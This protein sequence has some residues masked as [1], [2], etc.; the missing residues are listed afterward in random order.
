MGD[1]PRNLA[2]PSHVNAWSRWS[3]GTL[4]ARLS[5]LSLPGGGVGWT[6]NVAIYVPF[7]LSWPYNV[8]RAFWGNGNAV[9]GN[10]DIGIYTQG[11]ARLWSSGSTAC[12]GPTNSLQYVTTS[13]DLTLQPGVP[14]FFGFTHDSSTASHLTGES[15]SAM[16]TPWG[17]ACG[18]YQQA[19]AFPLPAAAT[20]AA[21]AAVGLP[22]I[23]ITNTDSGF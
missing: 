19:S 15:G 12:S 21:Y 13:P 7:M 4:G 17:R 9:A 14:Y 23:G 3:I 5:A 6:A 11:G 18:L 8:R 2:V 20:F 22:L 16:T 1:Y 10:C